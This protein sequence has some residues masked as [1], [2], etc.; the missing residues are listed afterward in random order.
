MQE[1]IESIVLNI[2]QS[3]MS[4]DAGQCF[5][6]DQNRKIPNDNKIYVSAGMISSVP[7]YASMPYLEQDGE[8]IKEINEVQL[9]EL[10]QIDVFCI[11]N[12]FVK[13]RW[14]FIAALNSIYAKQMQ[15]KYNFKIGRLPNSFIN[16]SLAEGGSQLNRYTFTFSCF[17]WYKKEKIL[18]PSGTKYFDHFA[19]RV[20]DEKTIG[21]PE[22]VFDLIFQGEENDFVTYNGENVTYL[23]ENVI[24]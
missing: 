14:E 11:S 15:E 4:L 23:G 5:I 13:R 24:I 9:S 1:Q 19:V 3:E 6:R 17:T 21:K 2:I 16:T 18:T 12:L 8:N 10:I 20:D 7:V 22:G